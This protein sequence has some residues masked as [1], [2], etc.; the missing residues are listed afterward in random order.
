MLEKFI[1]N[2]YKYNFF[3]NFK[4]YPAAIKSEC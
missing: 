1:K 4:K 3:V 2:N